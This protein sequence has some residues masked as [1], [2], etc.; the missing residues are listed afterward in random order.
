MKNRKKKDKEGKTKKD[1]FLAMVTSV[2]VKKGQEL[3]NTLGDCDNQELLYKYGFAEL[4]N[5][6]DVVAI[7]IGDSVNIAKSLAGKDKDNDVK[8]NVLRARNQIIKKFAELEFLALKE[9]EEKED[10]EDKVRHDDD[11]EDDRVEAKEEDQVDDDMDD[12]ED[13]FLIFDREFD[14]SALNVIKSALENVVDK[15]QVKDYA[16][17]LIDARREKYKD[18]RDA[19]TLRA[20]I[21]N[22]NPNDELSLSQKGA[23]L[24][25]QSE[26]QIL[27]TVRQTIFTAW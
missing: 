5:P 3:F 1:T 27:E 21:K 11:K 18:K 9:L 17:K 25:I 14:E 4:D 16:L 23:L 7:N 22:M 12:D 26:K 6:Y 24:L 19:D 8:T 20:F 15:S 13:S 2:A 10:E